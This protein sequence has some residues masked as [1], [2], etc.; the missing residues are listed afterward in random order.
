MRTKQT[1]PLWER[2]W[3][4]G[5]LTVLT[6]L[7]GVVLTGA[8]WMRVVE[9]EEAAARERFRVEAESLRQSVE[10]ELHQF[11]DVLDSIRALHGLSGEISP[12]ALDEFVERGM[13]HQHDVL[14]AF[15]FAQRISHNWRT[16]L[17]RAHE[18]VP[19]S[20]YL[21]T[22]QAGP[23]R[24]APAETRSMY[25]PLTW[26][27]RASA[28]GVPKGFDFASRLDALRAIE[29]IQA[30][31]EMAMVRHPI[32]SGDGAERV[33]WVFA[34]IFYA[35]ASDREAADQGF[36]AGFALGL[37]RPQDMLARVASQ[38][39]PSRG[40]RLDLSPGGAGASAG[41]VREDG[42]W[43]YAYPI[44]VIDRAWVFR[45]Y[46]PVSLRDRSHG[47][48]W[49]VGLLI[50][51]LM[52]S[53]LAL[54][55]GRTRRIEH[56]VRT[57]TDDLHRAKAALETQM[58]ERM[59]LEE[60]MSDLAARERQR[61]GRDLHDSLGQKLTG[62]V[63]LSRSLLGHCKETK[64]EQ[65]PHARTLNDTLKEAVAQVRGM[66]R[67][68]APVTLNDE[69]LGAAL[70]QLTEE[71]T[72]LYGVSCEWTGD[73]T[74]GTTLDGKTKEQLYLIAREAVNN[75]ARHARPNRIT[76]TLSGK[77]E[78]VELV[79]SDDG[80]GIAEDA[81]EQGGMGLRIMRYRARLINAAL[82]I[83]P[84][85]DGGTRVRCVR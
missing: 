25:F 50:T 7:T 13:Q 66:A 62:A 75:A 52:T 19:S 63:F 22:R 9:R 15:G 39:V 16:S 29:R 14:G 78:Q 45:C 72:Q 49:G 33:H 26:V 79:V 73:E 36:L 48:V 51:A 2:A 21:I 37:L 65:E 23:G 85:P 8:V 12:E 77:G 40:L 56:E 10:R 60:E 58:Q 20:G 32:T 64:S 1:D 47:S 18:D 28:L 68:L 27:S 24:W 59:R 34:P 17:E 46:L 84:G 42:E 6:A 38:N 41:V 35:D 74:P 70:G 43:H 61:L 69:H 53:Q 5:L 80:V 55:L 82:H 81:M 31:G 57:R 30:S 71:M 4:P 54:V 76:V 67:G 83:E 11:M 3:W 44:Q